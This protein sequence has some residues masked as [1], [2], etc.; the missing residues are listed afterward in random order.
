M[1]ELRPG[2]TRA[3]FGDVV[4]QVKDKVDPMTAAIER[5]VRGEHMDSDDLRLRRWEEVGDD[6]L[7]PAFHMRFQPGHVLY[8]SRR[9]YL[10]KVAV[11]DFEGVCANTTFVVESK[12]PAVLLPELL[13]FIMTTEDFHAHSIRESKGSVNP[14]V[15]FSDLAWYEFALPT[16]QEQ[17]RIARILKSADETKNRIQSAIDAAR[18]GYFALG[19]KLFVRPE[20]YAGRGDPSPRTWRPSGW[21]V[22]P[23]GE[24]NAPDAPICYGIVKLGDTVPNGVPVLRTENL[25]G[26]YTD[27]RWVDSKLDDAYRRSRVEGGDILLAIQGASTGKIGRVPLG[28]EGNIN[29]HVARLRCSPALSPSFFH[30]LWNSTSYSRYVTAVATGTTKP[31]LTVGALRKLEVPLPVRSE[32]DASASQLDELLAGVVRFEERRV[33]AQALLKTLTRSLLG[34]PP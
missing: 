18:V 24:L 4:R 34:G 2:W 5:V 31:E 10:R 1:G 19:N 23:L 11:A 32:Q 13:P 28:F 22:R 9:T 17:R 12:N 3:K 16:L 6:Y 26:D 15:N 29:R 27:L 8:G 20:R 33:S 25:N 7:G 21:Q 14:Y 30:H